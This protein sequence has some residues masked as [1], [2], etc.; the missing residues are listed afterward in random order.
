MTLW[1]HADAHLRQYVPQGRSNEGLCCAPS[2]LA[3]AVVVLVVVQKYWG[4][5]LQDLSL[6]MI[7]FRRRICR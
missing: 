5:P 6:L 2:V 1:R 7:L 4:S 3:P